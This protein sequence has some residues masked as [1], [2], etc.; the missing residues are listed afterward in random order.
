MSGIY[1]SNEKYL[2]KAKNYNSYIGNI[3]NSVPFIYQI[4]EL[5]KV[6]QYWLQHKTLSQLNKDTNAILINP[7]QATLVRA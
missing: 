3:T 2:N 6:K 5:L 4:K 1:H 7:V